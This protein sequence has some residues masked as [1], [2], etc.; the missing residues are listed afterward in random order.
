MLIILLNSTHAQFL[1]QTSL[2]SLYQFSPN[3]TLLICWRFS[4][5][6]KSNE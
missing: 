5:K 3:F 6:E 2:V 1:L 4:F